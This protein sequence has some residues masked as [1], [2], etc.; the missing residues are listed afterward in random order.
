LKG[1]G[2]YPR[3]QSNPNGDASTGIETA[4]I[5]IESQLVAPGAGMFGP[6]QPGK[7]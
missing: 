4:S 7:Q 3:S 1:A 6:A 5:V 2:Q